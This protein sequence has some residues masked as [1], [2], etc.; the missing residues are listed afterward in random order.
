[1]TQREQLLTNALEATQEYV[2]LLTDELNDFAPFALNHGIR[3]TRVEAGKSARDKI[4]KALDALKNEPKPDTITLPRETTT[5]LII[6]LRN[7]QSRS[8][9]REPYQDVYHAKASTL[10]DRLKLALNN[11][12]STKGKR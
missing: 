6:L 4:S 9:V 10:V 8:L 3:S 12:P 7:Y 11:Q 1:M 5:D 2:A